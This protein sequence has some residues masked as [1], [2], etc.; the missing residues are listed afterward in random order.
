MKSL[1]TPRNI[2]ALLLGAGVL[3]IASMIL[4]PDDLGEEEFEDDLAYGD[5]D[6]ETS[7]GDVSSFVD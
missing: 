4:G 7:D 5:P 2:I 6:G 1:F 3:A